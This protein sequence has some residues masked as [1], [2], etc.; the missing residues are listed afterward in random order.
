MQEEF[1]TTVYT[2]RSHTVKA[3]AK[4]LLTHLFALVV[5]CEDSSLSVS[6]SLSVRGGSGVIVHSS[7]Q[8]THHHHVEL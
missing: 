7:H 6:L 1:P 4:H 5:E 3:E 2:S 8:L